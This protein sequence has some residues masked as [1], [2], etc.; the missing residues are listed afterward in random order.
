MYVRLLVMLWFLLKLRYGDKNVIHITT[1]LHGFYVI[2]RRTKWKDITRILLTNWS[3]HYRGR[4]S[5]DTPGNWSVQQSG[6][7]SFRSPHGRRTVWIHGTQIG[8]WG[9]HGKTPYGECPNELGKIICVLLLC[10]VKLSIV[11]RINCIILQLSFVFYNLQF[12][13]DHL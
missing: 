10:K 7:R 4:S 8:A 5:K 9:F 6:Q 11:L 2:V 1:P 12:S 3:F 13:Y